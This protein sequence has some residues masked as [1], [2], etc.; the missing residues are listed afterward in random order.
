M[1]AGRRIGMKYRALVISRQYGSGGGRIAAIIAERLGWRLL[2]GQIIEAV[3]QAMRTSRAT[4]RT[5]DEHVARWFHRVNR[6]ALKCAALMGGTPCDDE[7]FLD[8]DSVAK[9]TCKVIEEAAA[10]GNCVVVGR[11]AQ[12]ILKNRRDVFR[13]FVS[14][15]VEQRLQSVRN[16]TGKP[17]SEKQLNDVD[18]E[19]VRYLSHYFGCKRDDPALYDLM[20]SSTEGDEQTA[21]AILRAMGCEVGVPTA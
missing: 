16:R 5:H 11:G 2:D 20:I 13:V 7:D 21:M 4:I 10:D 14:A 8:A 9:F 17:I 12:G 1:D 3:A 15:P 6:D 18:A 19:R